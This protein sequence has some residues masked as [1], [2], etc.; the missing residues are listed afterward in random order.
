MELTRYGVEMQVTELGH[1][2]EVREL[3]QLGGDRSAV[4]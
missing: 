4:L 2:E 1:V 3:P